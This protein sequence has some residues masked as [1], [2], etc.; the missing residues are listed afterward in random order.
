MLGN[1]YRLKCPIAI[2]RY[3]YFRAMVFQKHSLFCV[4]VPAIPAVVSGI[5]VFLVAQML[6]HFC[7]K[8]PL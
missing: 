8:S 4:P 1:Y 7:L 6:C 3:F 2:P 5:G